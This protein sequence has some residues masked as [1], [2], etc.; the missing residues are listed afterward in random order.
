MTRPPAAQLWLCIHLPAHEPGDSAPDEA[1]L[2]KLADWAMRFTP[3]VAVAVG[4]DAGDA[5]L[6]E[7]QGSLRLFGGLDALR[8]RIERSL[9]ALGNA[10]VMACAP[11]PRAALWLARAGIRTPACTHAQLRPMLT[12]VG[13]RHLGW[14]MRSVQ[15]LSQMGVATVGECLRLPRADLARR[16]GPDCVRALD[17]ALGRCPDPQAWHVPRSG[18]ADELELPAE[19]SDTTLLLTA[20]QQLFRRLRNRLEQEQASIR[21]VWC[22]LKHADG[23]ETRLRL[24]LQQAAGPVEATTRLPGL[25]GLRLAALHLPAPVVCVAL[26]TRLESGQSPI[27]TDLLGASLVPE[28]GLKLLLERLRAR[29]G[30]QAVQGIASWPE[31]R[32]EKA[33]RAVMNPMA[34]AV[35]GSGATATSH[36]WPMGDAS[37]PMGDASRPVW[38]LPVPQRLPLVAGQPAWHGRL[39]LEQGPERIESGWW[40]GDDIRRDYYRASN[41]QGA[42]LWVYHDLRSQ[43]WYLQGVFG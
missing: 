8:A 21:G 24:G 25:L 6:L 38:L 17:Q 32:P 41:P 31:H 3:A 20:F 7:I 18:F 13:L 40:D 27:G 28:G 29:L 26:Q 2:E 36:A 14:P 5:L 30:G 34:N 19:S 4:A 35:K 9:R 1:T 23:Q 37:R 39:H 15:A 12:G 16:L 22:R 10:A 43:G 42:M 33:W 11:T